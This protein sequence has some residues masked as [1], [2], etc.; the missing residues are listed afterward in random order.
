[1]MTLADQEIE[2]NAIADKAEI[3]VI[4]Q[5]T[6][7]APHRHP[8]LTLIIQ[9]DDVQSRVLK[10]NLMTSEA[11]GTFYSQFEKYTLSL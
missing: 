2:L 7:I 1:M 6:P 8:T 4:A 10:S 5:I 9:V 3:A 11:H